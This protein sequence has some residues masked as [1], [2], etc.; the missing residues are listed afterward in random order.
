MGR[1]SWI[2]SS[3]NEW[4]D[5]WSREAA[6]AATAPSYR[7]SSNRDRD[8]MNVVTRRWQLPPVGPEYA[9]SPRV[10][11]AILD[12]LLTN[13]LSVLEQHYFARADPVRPENPP[14][15]ND[16]VAGDLRQVTRLIAVV[17]S[18]L[19]EQ[20]VTDHDAPFHKTRDRLLDVDIGGIAIVAA[21][22]GSPLPHEVTSDVVRIAAADR[23][24]GV[25]SIQ[26]RHPVAK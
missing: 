24:D 20:A 25:A 4:P 5:A 23:G 22:V 1:S 10:A 14:V 18:Y 12:R 9:A 17:H 7:A 26:Q 8:K 2:D 19:D 13:E 16:V 3:S 21:N 6:C 11:I 15:H